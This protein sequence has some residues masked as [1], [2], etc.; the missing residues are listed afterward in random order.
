MG[1]T[2]PKPKPKNNQLNFTEDDIRSRAYEIW[3]DRNGTGNSS[4]GK[5]NPEDDWNAA[6][7]SLKLERSKLK[8]INVYLWKPF[9]SSYNLTKK[10]T[11]NLLRAFTDREDRAFN[12]DVVIRERLE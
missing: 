8:R 3:C 7:E 6:I 10:S 9:N 1:K 11:Q 12:L 5:Y 4:N 2:P